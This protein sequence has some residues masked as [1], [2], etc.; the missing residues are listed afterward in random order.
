MVKNNGTLKQFCAKDEA[1][2]DDDGLSLYLIACFFMPSHTF[3]TLQ[4]HGLLDI[5]N[6][7]VNT[8]INCT[9]NHGIWGGMFGDQD[10]STSF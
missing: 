10:R 9:L 2:N 7:I 3:F 5:S 6:V 8:Y 4:S 1:V